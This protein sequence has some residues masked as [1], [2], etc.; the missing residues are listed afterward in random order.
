MIER[1]QLRA[2]GDSILFTFLD[3]ARG[4]MFTPKISDTIIVQIADITGQD[5]PRWGLVVAVG[6]EVGEEVKAGS[7]VLIDALKW[8]TSITLPDKSKIW[9]TTYPHVSAISDTEVKS[10]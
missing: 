6:P 10:Y 1:M 7:Y 9:K 5:A 2:L 3:E 4:G 8:T